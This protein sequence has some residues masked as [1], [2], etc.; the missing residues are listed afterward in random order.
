LRHYSA[1]AL[2]AA[3]LAACNQD[4]DKFSFPNGG[5]GSGGALVGGN[6]DGGMP[7]TGGSASTAAATALEVPCGGDACDVDE[8]EVC[9]LAASDGSAPHCATGCIGG[10]ALLVCNGASDCNGQR[11]CLVTA[12]NGDYKNSECRQSCVVGTEELCDPSDDPPCASGGTCSADAQ[13]T[14]YSICD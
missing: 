6:A 7:G 5:A 9:C 14:G 8:G 1:F 10:E 11:C 12:S 13:L 4:Y 3:T 2:L